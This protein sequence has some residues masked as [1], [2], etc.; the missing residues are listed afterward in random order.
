MRVPKSAPGGWYRKP[1]ETPGGVPGAPQRSHRGGQN[2]AQ[3]APKRGLKKGPL[4][5]PK[6][7]KPLFFLENTAFSSFP[8][9][10]SRRALGAPKATPRVAPKGSPGAPPG[11]PPGAAQEGPERRPGGP[12]GG[13]KEAPAE[14]ARSLQNDSFFGCGLDHSQYRYSHHKTTFLTNFFSI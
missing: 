7:C 12:P 11:P 8:G 14:R 13:L 6:P 9:W 2:E 10:A 4:N 3:E 5:E 1:W